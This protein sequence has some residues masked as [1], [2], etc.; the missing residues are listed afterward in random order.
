[1]KFWIRSFSSI[2]NLFLGYEGLEE[3]K[4]QQKKIRRKLLDLKSDDGKGKQQKAPKANQFS[5][6]F[7]NKH[8]NS[9]YASEVNIQEFENKDHLENLWRTTVDS[10]DTKQTKDKIIMKRADIDKI[11]KTNL[12]QSKTLKANE[13]IKD[14]DSV[15]SLSRRKQAL[16]KHFKYKAK[17]DKTKRSDFVLLF[18][19]LFRNLINQTDIRKDMIQKY[20]SLNFHFK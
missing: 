12:V 8:P 17:E 16:I 10:N 19:I 6:A 3:V 5:I 20:L 15:S 18:L 7:V 2:L 13:Q 4:Y 9:R 11:N 1:M 14:Q